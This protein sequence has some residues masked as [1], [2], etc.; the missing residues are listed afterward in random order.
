M[1][2]S[3]NIRRTVRALL[4]PVVCGAALLTNAAIAQDSGE[5]DL[6]TEVPQSVIDEIVVV[7]GQSRT[8]LRAQIEEAENA[9]YARF[10]EINSDDEFDISCRL[11]PINNSRMLRRVCQGNYWIEASAKGGEEIARALQGFTG[12][13]PQVYSSEQHRKTVQMIDEMREL[14]RTDEEFRTSLVRLANLQNIMSEGR[15]DSRP[16]QTFARALAPT[17]GALP[18]DA[19]LV[20]QVQTGRQAWEHELTHR[21][22]TI[23]QVYGEIRSVEVEC[24]Q[25]RERLQYEAE[26]EWQLPD[27]WGACTLV[28]DGERDTTFALYEFQ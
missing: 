1:S 23:A 4:I 2:F 7:R 8:F 22:F 13:S 28:V 27:G 18:Y 25:R 16:T 12:I 24:E 20:F 5:A 14:A 9:M 15:N 21:T 10:N 3:K 19:D 6:A 17:E 11:Q 26:I